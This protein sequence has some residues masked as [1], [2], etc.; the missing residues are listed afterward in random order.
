MRRVEWKATVGSSDTYDRDLSPLLSSPTPA[1]PWLKIMAHRW[2]HTLSRSCASWGSELADA[3]DVRQL[4]QLCSDDSRKRSPLAY[5]DAVVARNCA[6]DN[7]LPS[8]N[9]GAERV[10]P[11]R[12]RRA[13][14]SS[15][16]CVP[17]TPALPGS[18]GIAIRLSSEERTRAS[19]AWRS[20]R[21]GSACRKCNSEAGARCSSCSS[22]SSRS[23][24][25]APKSYGAAALAT[26]TG[27]RARSACS[28]RST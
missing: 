4:H 5:A 11:L 21:A 13:I 1:F 20:A 8:D 7:M 14:S 18:Q 2:R 15:V 12:R 23:G 16:A 6:T 27:T 19:S 3:A 26:T 10:M 24:A 17:C 22:K 25:A 28:A 9:R